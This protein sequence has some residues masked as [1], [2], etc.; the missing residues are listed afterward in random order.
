MKLDALPSPGLLAN[1]LRLQAES[2]KA[3]SYV[4]V[5]SSLKSSG[6]T[7][8]ATTLTAFWTAC[9]AAVAA[10]VDSVVPAIST[11]TVAPATGANKIVL[12]YA[13]ELDPNYVPATTAFA[14]TTTVRTVTDVEIIGTKVYLTVNTPFVAGNTINVAYTQPGASTNLRDLSGNYAASFTAAAVTNTLA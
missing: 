13:E 6:K 1:G 10:F 9:I 5:V 8:Q 12:T 2:I 14:V 11:R 7:E 4:E 3:I